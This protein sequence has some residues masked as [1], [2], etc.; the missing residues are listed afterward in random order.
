MNLM[1]VPAL[2]FL[3]HAFG[4]YYRDIVN[5]AKH[6]VTFK[7]RST[8]AAALANFEKAV[9]RHC[10]GIKVHFN[11]RKHTKLTE[12][13]PEEDRLKFSSF[14]VVHGNGD[15]AVKPRFTKAIADAKQA[16]EEH[17]KNN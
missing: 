15:Y 10:H 7:W 9:R 14:L 6:N 8:F 2:A 17:D 3:R 13:I 11:H 4:V 12:Q 5:V 1:T 16:A